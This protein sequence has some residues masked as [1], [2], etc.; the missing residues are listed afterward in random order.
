M[1]E[2]AANNSLVTYSVIG[3]S[4]NGIEIGQSVIQTGGN[5]KQSI[6]LECGI[7]AR[8]WVSPAT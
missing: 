2:T 1:K 8:E 5:A 7:H 3:Y 6:F 4:Y